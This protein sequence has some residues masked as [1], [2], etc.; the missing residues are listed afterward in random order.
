MPTV[1]TAMSKAEL[2]ALIRSRGDYTN[3]RRFPTD[4]LDAEIQTAFGHAYRIID[5][6]HQGWWDT[7][8]TLSTVAGQGYVALAAGMKVIKGVDRLDG[9]DYDELAQVGLDQRNRFGNSRG[10]PVAFR[11]SARG[12]EIYPPPDAV[13]TL[14]VMYTPKPP[15]LTENERREWYD[16]WSDFVVEKVL[17]ELDSREGRPMGD[18]TAKLKMAEEALRASSNQRKQSEPD[19]LP[20][21][22]GVGFDPFDTGLI[23]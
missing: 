17:F 16:G 13:Y 8:G 12:L 18:R 6:A 3:V 15:L 23:D 1:D 11:P 19:Y 21:R 7:E 14:R 22:G 20:L 10:K 4:Y 2:R 9:T 5:E